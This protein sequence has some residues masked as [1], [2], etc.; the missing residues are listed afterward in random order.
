[1]YGLDART[2]AFLLAL[3]LTACAS[4]NNAMTPSA[5]VI[6]DKF[7]D[8]KI[9]RQEPVSASDALTG[10]WHTLGFEWNSKQPK[11]V[12]V[13][14]GTNG[15]VPITALAF[16]A[17]GQKLPP[18]TLASSHSETG[19]GWSTRGSSCRCRTS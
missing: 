2:T 5:Q 17:D 13:T 9:I 19:D 11:E 1:M 4:F 10:A 7:D 18:A 3:S 16:N 6:E 12:F 15:I 8:A 14:A